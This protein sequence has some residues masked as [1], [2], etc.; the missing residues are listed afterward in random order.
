MTLPKYASLA[1]LALAACSQEPEAPEAP[2]PTATRAAPPASTTR[3]IPENLI[4]ATYQGAW[5]WTG[6]TCQSDSDQR[7]EIGGQEIHFYESVG[8]VQRVREASGALA[9][10]LAMEGEGMEWT[11]TTVLRM[12]EG[13]LLETEYD[14]PSGTGKLRLKRC[15]E[16]TTTP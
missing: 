8:E 6:G 13:G 1:L 11:Q 5:D 4:P 16:E 7:M 15:T 14:D 12:V 10:D 2:A 3:I 9:V